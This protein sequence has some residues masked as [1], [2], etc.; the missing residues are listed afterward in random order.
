MVEEKNKAALAALLGIE[1]DE[2]NLDSHLIKNGNKGRLILQENS[3]RGL[4]ATIEV[5][6]GKS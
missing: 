1:E 2:V 4:K 6:H 3:P 5:P